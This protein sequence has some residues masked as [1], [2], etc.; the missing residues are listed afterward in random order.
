MYREISRSEYA[1]AWKIYR[2][3]WI[4][5]WLSL[6]ASFGLAIFFATNVPSL[7]GVLAVILGVVPY[8]VFYLYF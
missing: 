5:A 8:V 2:M 6:L 7:P 1:A 3:R 4:L